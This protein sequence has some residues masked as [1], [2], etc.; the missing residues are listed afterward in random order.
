MQTARDFGSRF[1][2]GH[3][4]G[5]KNILYN[6][7]QHDGVFS[8]L[9][10]Y[11]FVE[12]LVLIRKRVVAALCRTK[13]RSAW[14]GEWFIYRS[15]VKPVLLL[16]IYFHFGSVLKFPGRQQPDPLGL[17]SR[18]F[19]FRQTTTLSSFFFLKVKEMFCIS[20]HF[21]RGKPSQL[22]FW[23]MKLIIFPWN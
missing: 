12:S 23:S 14:K 3:V 21:P 11:F 9:K 16:T 5:K 8:A 19:P 18:R 22:I 10:D 2:L 1:T 20:K 17:S 13:T 4:K 15:L 7:W 6:L